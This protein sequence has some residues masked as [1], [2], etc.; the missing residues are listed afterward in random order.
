MNREA[1]FEQLLSYEAVDRAFEVFRNSNNIIEIDGQ[2]KDRHWVAS[3][4]SFL[5]SK[6]T[7]DELEFVWDEIKDKFDHQFEPVYFRIL[8]YNSGCHI[9]EHVDT[10]AE[11]QQESDHSLIIQMNSPDDYVGGLPSVNGNEVCLNI[12]DAVMYEYGVPHAVSPVTKGIRY[13][14]NMRLKKVK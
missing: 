9:P 2:S 1:V 11:W 6:F 7:F 13:V 3:V 5:L 8:K 4:G 12:G 10:Y 14:I